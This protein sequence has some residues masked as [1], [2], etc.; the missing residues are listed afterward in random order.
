MKGVWSSILNSSLNIHYKRIIPLPTLKKS[1][2][3]AT[4]CFLERCVGRIYCV[5]NRFS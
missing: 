3:N 4:K 2:G 5:V 1:V